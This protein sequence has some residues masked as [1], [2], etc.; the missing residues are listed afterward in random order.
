M[1]F[2]EYSTREQWIHA[3]RS[4]AGWTA[5]AAGI[6][7]FRV[8]MAQVLAVID[9]EA[10]GADEAGRSALTPEHVATAS[11]AP[12]RTVL[13]IRAGLANSGLI[14]HTA[15]ISHTTMVIQLQVPR[16]TTANAGHSPLRDP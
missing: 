13:L 9:A 2:P 8:P 10:A 12:L 5:N 1:P 3:A 14:S 15:H 4:A 6:E 11:G 7:R 16:G